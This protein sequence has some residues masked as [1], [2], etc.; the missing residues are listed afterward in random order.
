MSIIIGTNFKYSSRKFLD[1]RS[2]CRNL[3]ELMMNENNYL[4]PMGFEVYCIEERA[5]YYNNCANEN[6]FPLWILRNNNS[7]E[8]GGSIDDTAPSAST[9]YS[10]MKVSQIT[11]ELN[12]QVNINTQSIVTINDNMTYLIDEKYDNV[13]FDNNTLNFYANNTLVDTVEFNFEVEGVKINDELISTETVYSSNK[14]NILLNNLKSELG[15]NETNLINDEEISFETTYS[16][17]KIENEISLLENRASQIDDDIMEV[18]SRVDVNADEILLINANSL[19]MNET[20]NTTLLATD[21]MYQIIEPLIDSN[22]N[23]MSNSQSLKN[24]EKAYLLMVKR[25]IKNI[26][27]V[28]LRFRETIRKML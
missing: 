3:A 17:E 8:S 4:Y 2:Q 23:T 24:I 18:N 7:G 9:T 21:E 14:I 13:I 5:W 27:E 11:N 28:P 20:I 22:A 10:S 6:D 1:E 16:S 26:E 19:S 15:T 25:G 12:R